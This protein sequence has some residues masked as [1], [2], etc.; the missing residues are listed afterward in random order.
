MEKHWREFLTVLSRSDYW[1]MRSLRALGVI[2]PQRGQALLA[3]SVDVSPWATTFHI[4][5]IAALRRLHTG[6]S[7]GDLEGLEPRLPPR[8]ALYSS[9][10]S[11]VPAFV[12]RA[13]K[14]HLHS[15]VCAWAPF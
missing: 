5:R 10:C 13:Y 14:L 3:E 2:S 6:S 4:L 11:L 1:R 12:D 15:L 9:P 7:P 8:S